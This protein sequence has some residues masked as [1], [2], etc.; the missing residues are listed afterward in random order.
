MCACR[1]AQHW[2]GN[3]VGTETLSLQPSGKGWGIHRKSHKQTGLRRR[4]WC[5]WMGCRITAT[6]AWTHCPANGS[7]SSIVLKFQAWFTPCLVNVWSFLVFSPTNQGWKIML[8][9]SQQKRWL[10]YWI[11]NYKASVK[12]HKVPI[13]VPIWR[14]KGKYVISGSWYYRAKA[15]YLLMSFYS[16]DGGGGEMVAKWKPAQPWE[17][18]DVPKARNHVVDAHNRW[19]WWL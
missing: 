17:S 16:I 12:S 5:C 7:A 4:D 15:N 19:N 1:P 6:R 3:H 14:S 9:T 2:S 10:C 18:T 13:W 11:E 8:L